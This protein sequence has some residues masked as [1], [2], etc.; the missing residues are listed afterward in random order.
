M[1]NRNRNRIWEVNIG[2]RN[3]NIGNRKALY[4]RIWFVQES[5]TKYISEKQTMQNAV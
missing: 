2:N 1:G 4:S 3:I 5:K